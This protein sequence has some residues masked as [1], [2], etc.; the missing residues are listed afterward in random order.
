MTRLLIYI[1]NY[2]YDF[3]NY[4]MYDTDLKQNTTY[5]FYYPEDEDTDISLSAFVAQIHL[6]RNRE[7]ATTKIRI[8]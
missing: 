6:G 7:F 1:E 2:N 5:E 8:L 3:M 4:I